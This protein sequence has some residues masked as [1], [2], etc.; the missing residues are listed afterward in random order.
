MK[1][2]TAAG[3]RLQI[4]RAE[5]FHRAARKHY[6]D[7]VQAGWLGFMNSRTGRDLVAYM[8]ALYRARWYSGWYYRLARR[9]QLRF[10][11]WVSL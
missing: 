3:V 4:E 7:M 8:D 1:N 5:A 2:E 10:P 11:D 6:D 9:F